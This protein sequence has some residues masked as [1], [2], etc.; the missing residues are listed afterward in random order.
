[1]TKKLGRLV[2]AQMTA[3]ITKQTAHRHAVATNAR[4]APPI[5]RPLITSAANAYGTTPQPRPET[6]A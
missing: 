3:L 4:G 2:R 6:R 1:M 5:P